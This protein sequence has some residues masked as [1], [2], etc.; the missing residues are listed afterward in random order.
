MP[1][2][3]DRNLRSGNLKEE[4]GVLL[5]K[6]LAAVAEVQ[7]TEDFGI[8]AI[9]TLLRPVNRRELYAE[10]TFFVQIKTDPAPLSASCTAKI[11]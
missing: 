5:L 6:G 4:L 8:D 11:P 9:V 1:A 3:L 10:K 2:K 7:R